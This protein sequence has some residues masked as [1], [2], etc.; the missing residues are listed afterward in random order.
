M[1]LEVLLAIAELCHANGGQNWSIVHDYEL[2]CQQRYIACFESKFRHNKK[3]K[4]GDILSECV[5][6]SDD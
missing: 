5:V 2:D 6:Q 1:S 4:E 3:R